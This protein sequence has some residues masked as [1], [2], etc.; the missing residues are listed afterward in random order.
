MALEWGLNRS[1]VILI[2]SAIL[3]LAGTLLFMNRY[4]LVTPSRKGTPA[5]FLVD[6]LTGKAWLIEG[7]KMYRIAEPS[8]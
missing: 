3:A 7:D 1:V 8:P 4:E 6:R 2:S 5:A